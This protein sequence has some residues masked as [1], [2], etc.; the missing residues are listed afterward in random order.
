MEFMIQR[1][2][3]LKELQLEIDL[4]GC[5]LDDH[6]GLGERLGQ[7]RGHREPTQHRV[8]LGGG[9]LAQLDALADDVRDGGPPPVDRPLRHV[10]DARVEA[11]GDRR[12]SDPVPHRARADDGDSHRAIS[13]ITCM[14]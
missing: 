6:A 9:D 5:R 3:L 10:V 2:D 1:G 4:L 8:G 12:V 14:A 7:R 11:A 13:A